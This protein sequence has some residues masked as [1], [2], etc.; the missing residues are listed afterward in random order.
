MGGVSFTRNEKREI[1]WRE[2]SSTGRG[3]ERESVD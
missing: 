1:N 2:M 3:R